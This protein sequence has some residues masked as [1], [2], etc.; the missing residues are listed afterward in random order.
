MKMFRGVDIQIHVFLT[1]ALVVSF[2]LRQLYPQQ[3]TP[4]THYIVDWV[5]Y[6]SGLDYREKRNS[7]AHRNSNFIPCVVQPTVS[8]YIDCV[9][10][11]HIQLRVQKPLPDRKAKGVVEWPVFTYE[12]ISSNDTPW[13]D[14][15]IPASRNPKHENMCGSCYM[16]QWNRHATPRGEQEL[17]VLGKGLAIGN[18]WTE[19][20]RIKQHVEDIT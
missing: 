10:A 2:T 12:L 7:W 5:G 13:N 3:R 19:E 16:W 6:R 11:A 1:P 20:R 4:C 9:I 15:V 8:H 17:P 18:V 14:T